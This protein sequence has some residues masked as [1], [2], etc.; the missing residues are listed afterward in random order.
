MPIQAWRKWGRTPAYGELCPPEVWDRLQCQGNA[1]TGVWTFFEFFIALDVFIRRE[2]AMGLVALY[3][4]R[5]LC[6][7]GKLWKIYLKTFRAAT[8][9]AL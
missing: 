6:W 8:A 9:S 4:I 2:D 1:V 5:L 7:F 3:R